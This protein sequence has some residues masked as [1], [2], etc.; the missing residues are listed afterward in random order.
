MMGFLLVLELQ[1]VELARL[2]LERNGMW[3]VQSNVTNSKVQGF[4]GS[5]LFKLGIMKLIRM[6]YC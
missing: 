3:H 5:I 2:K 1:I 4:Q 6:C